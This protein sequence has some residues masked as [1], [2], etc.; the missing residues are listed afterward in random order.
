[1]RARLP[2]APP[3]RTARQRARG[4]GLGGAVV[5]ALLLAPGL[6]GRPLVSYASSASMVPVL[7]IGDGFLVDPLP[8]AL[9][10]GDI[11]VY[12]SEL[13]GGALAVHRIV[14]GDAQ[15]WA[16][17][18]DANAASD[19]QAGEP[20]VTPD[21]VRGRVLALGGQ[22][23]VAPG[24]GVPFIEGAALLRQAERAGIGAAEL[25]AA[26]A[27]LAAAALLLAPRRA[28]DAPEP[29][30]PARAR[31]AAAMR[32]AM[33]Q[34]AQGKH[35]ALAALLV[36]TAV[37]AAA[38]SAL[39]E[40]IPVSLV[41]L[42]EPPPEQVR[43]TTPGADVPRDVEVRSLP[44]LPT[45]AIVE[46][47][48]PRV[49]V[50]AQPMHIGAGSAAVAQV[51]EVAGADRGLQQDSVHVWRYPALLPDDATM[52]LHRALPGLPLLLPAL[53]LLAALALALARLGVA[54]LPLR[55]LLGPGGAWR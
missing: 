4:L 52:A 44:L 39:H 46:P 48:T 50:P 54:H 8:G 25:G 10:L 49:R 47:G 53:A 1:M 31:A 37:A 38:A 35:A 30:T 23:L 45:L 34:G 5:V 17:Q 21:R 27:V 32:R 16:T 15:G 33:P 28:P 26:L 19:Q 41:V 6:A 3:T 7:G 42:E 51:R 13:R 40:E 12:S 14:G 36:L 55:A 20:F 18:G 11:V 43:S 9:G 29:R 24:L 2:P 22:P